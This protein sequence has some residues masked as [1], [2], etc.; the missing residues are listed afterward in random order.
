VYSTPRRGNGCAVLS[1]LQ[2][3]YKYLDQTDVMASMACAAAAAAAPAAR[4]AAP[5]RR[6]GFRVAVGGSA[7]NIN[8][9]ARRPP[10]RTAAPVRAAA[11]GD[12]KF[13]WETDDDF[14]PAGKAAKNK[15]RPGK[16]PTQQ[17]QKQTAQNAAAAAA[18]PVAEKLDWENDDF[19]PASKAGKSKKKPKAPGPHASAAAQRGAEATAAAAD[20][21]DAGVVAEKLDWEND[22]F[23]PASRANRSKKKTPRG[24][25]SL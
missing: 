3:P 8:N 22:D 24:G 20:T 2:L 25:A 15:K 5:T 11:G 14:V 9:P 18:R 17:Q 6:L 19:V 13:D 10:T 23:V 21:A 7:L 12:Q 4:V 16:A 1:E